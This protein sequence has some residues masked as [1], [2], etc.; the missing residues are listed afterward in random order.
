M[1]DQGSIEAKRKVLE[2]KKPSSSPKEVLGFSF[3]TPI[4]KKY[5]KKH[6]KITVIVSNIIPSGQLIGNSQRILKPFNILD[7]KSETEKNEERST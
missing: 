3:L 6:C 2:I 1:Q 4:K 5:T 7:T